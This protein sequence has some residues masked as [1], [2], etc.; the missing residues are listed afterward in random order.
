M[1]PPSHS[2]LP[3]WAHA[4][5]LLLACAFLLVACV[6]SAPTPTPVQPITGLPAGTDGYPWWNDTV[7]Y[8]IFV[9]SFYDSDGDGIGDFNGIIEQLDYL[10]DSDPS[11]STDL[12]VTGLWLM[13][14]HPSPSYHG[15]DVSDYYAVNPDYGT[16][17]DFERLLAEAQKRGIRVI[18][19]LVLNHTSTH[20]PW[21]QESKNPNSPYRDWYIWT[22]T[23]PG[24]VGPWNQSVWHS[25]PSGY[26]YG[27]F[28]EGMPDLNYNH[29]EVTAQMKDVARFWL[30]EVGVDGFRLDGAKHLIEDGEDQENTAMTHTWWK[31]FQIFYKGLHPQAL[32]V[33]E[34]WSANSEVVQYAQG[35]MFDLVF[36]FDLAAAMLRSA[37]DRNARPAQEVFVN[38]VEL[39]NPGAF[40][41]FLTNHDMNRVIVQLLDSQEK[42]RQAAT[43]L[44]TGPGV[45][46]IYY[47]EELGMT[48][49]KPDERIR[50]PMQWSAESNGGFTTGTP[51]AVPHPDYDEKNVAAQTD[52]PDSLL[53]HY[54]T[55]IQLRNQHAA[56]RIGDYIPVEADNRAILSFLRVSKGEILLVIVNLDREPVSDFSLSLASGP[57]SGDY[58]AAALL[59]PSTLSSQEK[60]AAPAVHSQGGFDI[61]QP[62]SEFP[63]YSSLIIQLQPVK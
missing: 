5:R 34:V 51:W 16:L 41:T 54:R 22:D 24:F 8:E 10:N 33:G 1:H 47:G 40:A 37:G 36:N 35:D 12:G 23:H 17:D 42:A 58:Q 45:P 19:D 44:L 43:L 46:F 21:F 13:P 26:Y 15:Y 59:R 4:G 62:V 61:Y 63:A 6:Q 30:E 25:D 20:H 49:V 48:G 50:T 27:V 18:I 31:E 57:L 9:R 2:I 28:W 29:A 14:I 3:R 60:I 56:L 53:S 55:L 52:D 11:T 39:F 7:F 38:S 32:T